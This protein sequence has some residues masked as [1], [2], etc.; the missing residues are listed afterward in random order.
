M[1]LSDFRK[2]LNYFYQEDN[3]VRKV[4][5]P[6]TLATTVG[7]Y[8]K[9]QLKHIDEK[10]FRSIFGYSKSCSFA[11]RKNL[12][13]QDFESFKKELTEGIKSNL[14]GQT[15]SGLD[16]IY[17]LL[18]H[19]KIPS[20]NTVVVPEKHNFYRMRPTDKYELF[21]RDGMFSMPFQLLENQDTMRYNEQGYSCL[22]LANSLY[23][24]WEE[25]RRPDITKVNFSRYQNQRKISLLDLTIPVF[26][27]KS[28]DFLSAFLALLCCANVD[29]D[30]K[31]YKFEYV[32]PNM[33]LDAVIRANFD[34]KCALDGIRY[35][36]AKRFGADRL[37]FENQTELMYDYVFPSMEFG[38]KGHSK[39]LRNLFKLTNGRSLFLYNLH[40]VS[41]KRLP[42]MTTSY[43]DTIFYELEQ[44]SMLES[45]E[46]IK[47][48]ESCE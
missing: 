2:S 29:N 23:L 28:R 32:V 41:I 18:F 8:F 37:E 15:S 39:K 48:N 42:A 44:L 22:Y 4:G 1:T 40:K 45:L 47:N 38:Y 46:K 10:E 7:D 31:K 17:K 36:S 12:I 26:F 21:D 24:S 19:S 11:D 30:R 13:I 9:N 6:L 16:K 34:G 20:V 3:S 27:T 25:T 5:D 35:I 14:E 43:K 33:V